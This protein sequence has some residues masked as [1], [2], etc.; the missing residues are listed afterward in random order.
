MVQKNKLAPLVFASA[1]KVVLTKEGLEA[2]KRE[3][4]KLIK[5]KRPKAVERMVEA[6]NMGDLTENSEYTAA[7]QDLAFID[8]RISELE[9][10]LKTAKVV[11]SSGKAKEKVTVGSKVTL[12]TNKKKVV[13]TIVGEWEADPAKNK[14]SLSSP[15]GKA[16]VGKKVGN[17]IEVQAPAG[18]TTYQ[19]LEIK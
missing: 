3:Y 19:I 4:Q 15:L 13:F 18:K 17:R 5:V 2:L 14:I 7:R 6:R 8:G 16:L 1:K 11:K 9:E 12:E 10:I